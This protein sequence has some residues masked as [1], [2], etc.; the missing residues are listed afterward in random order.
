MEEPTKKP[1]SLMQL[2]GNQKLNK[3]KKLQFKK[4][5]KLRAKDG[6]HNIL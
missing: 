4:L 2:E 6:K 5:K 3:I 1:D